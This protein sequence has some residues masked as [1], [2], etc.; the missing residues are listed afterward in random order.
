V[1]CHYGFAVRGLHRLQI[2]TLSDN[3]AMIRIAGKAG[4]TQEGIL[5][6]SSWVG[7]DF[8]DE[9]ILGLLVTEWHRT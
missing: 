4:F 6:K 9:V 5:R 1:L 8:V 2:E 7:G 3:A